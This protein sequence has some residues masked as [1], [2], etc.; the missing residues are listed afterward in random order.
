MALAKNERAVS[1]GTMNNKRGKVYSTDA[2]AHAYLYRQVQKRRCKVMAEAKNDRGIN[3][4]GPHK[5]ICCEAIAHAYIYRRQNMMTDE[6]VVD[7]PMTIDLE[8]APR[9]GAIRKPFE[10]NALTLDV[11]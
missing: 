10:T 9:S 11:T 3:G 5:K 4:K 1:D 7:K 6:N 2:L 8:G